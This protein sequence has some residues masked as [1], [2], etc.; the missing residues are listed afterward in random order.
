MPAER[1]R[2][3]IWQK[4]VSFFEIHRGRP[5]HLTS[6]VS[7]KTWISSMTEDRQKSSCRP[8]RT[9]LLPNAQ[10]T[11][12]QTR[13]NSI[14]SPISLPNRHGCHSWHASLQS[15][16]NLKPAEMSPT[17]ASSIK[18]QSGTRGCLDPFIAKVFLAKSTSLV[19]LW[20]ILMMFP[21]KVIFHY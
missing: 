21:L 20:T 6:Y 16:G 5:R 1:R 2:V 4:P 10:D 11:A 19:G 12:F 9:N 8:T 13:K 18:A 17:L 7:P 3:L 15:T 14:C